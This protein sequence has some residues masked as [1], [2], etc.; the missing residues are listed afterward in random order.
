MLTNFYDQLLFL[1]VAAA[2]LYLIFRLLS[3]LSEVTMRGYFPAA[4][5]YYS[6][7]MVFSFFTV[8]YFKFVPSLRLGREST[9]FAVFDMTT[10]LVDNEEIRIRVLNY[11]S[12]FKEFVPYILLTGTLVFIVVT[13]VKRH[14]FKL[15]ILSSCRITAKEE[16]L[17][18]LY[19]CKREMG[20]KS[21][22]PVY[23]YS[24]ISTPF[25]YGCIKPFIV[26]PD[27]E[28]TPG[29]LRHIFLHE[30][31]HW[32]V[33]DAWVKCFILFVNA[34][35]WFNPIVYLA[36]R[37]IVRYCEL[38]CDES[39]V[40]RMDNRE[41]KRYCKLILGILWNI[42]G[43]NAK[44]VSAFN[45]DRKHLE[46]R[47]G[48]IMNKGNLK[49]KKSMIAVSIALT[50]L[51]AATGAFASGALNPNAGDSVLPENN[52]V[53]EGIG[54]STFSDESKHVFLDSYYKIE[55]EVLDQTVMGTLTRY[56]INRD[57]AA[58]GNIRGIDRINMSQGTKVRYTISWSPQPGV[59]RVGLYNLNT[60]RF[61]WAASSASS[62]LSGTI[63]VPET[64]LY[65]LAI[66]NTTDTSVKVTGYFMLNK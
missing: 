10:E 7:L 12:F 16:I 61:F 20:V 11:A 9:D 51:F 30:L 40:A 62:P 6:S 4:W 24:C 57:I 46:R 52:I 50:L 37:D 65:S 34:L 36:C 44:T 45:D 27:I 3:E 64:G 56:N 21:E 41:R 14:S 33:G 13:L 66:G 55:T 47:I 35:H 8:P 54:G 43:R 15:R 19:K 28:F 17:T 29:E 26:L 23:I 32:K 49:N 48:M 2:V 5:Q 63:T 18:M 31:T 25:I 39:V 42:A 59:I 1:S 38:S 53:E 58:V 60:G 22:F